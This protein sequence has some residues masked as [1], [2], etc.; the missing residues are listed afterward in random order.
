MESKNVCK[1]SP[2]I[3]ACSNVM[4]PQ[5]MLEILITHVEERE[6]PEEQIYQ[7]KP[8][9][10]LSQPIPLYSSN[11]CNPHNTKTGKCNFVDNPSTESIFLTQNEI[12]GFLDKIY[13]KIYEMTTSSYFLTFNFESGHQDNLKKRSRVRGWC[14]HLLSYRHSQYIEW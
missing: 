5:S 11:I 3:L 13:I 10:Y 4:L 9:S 7:V 8:N 2:C 1:M 6:N 14:I 12:L